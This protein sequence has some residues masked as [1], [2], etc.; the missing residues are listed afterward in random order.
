VPNDERLIMINLKGREEKRSWLILRFY[1]SI[2][3]E[4]PKKTVIN[5]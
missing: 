2:C 5:I 3:V 1:T 4:R